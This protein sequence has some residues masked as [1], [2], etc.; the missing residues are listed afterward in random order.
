[1][2]KKVI[3][4]YELRTEIAD[5]VISLL[6]MVLNYGKQ[7]DIVL[8]KKFQNVKIESLKLLGREID[9]NKIDKYAEMIAE[10]YLDSLVSR[11]ENVGTISEQ[12]LIQPITQ[13]HLKVQHV[14]GRRSSSDESSL[15]KL[16]YLKTSPRVITVHVR[17]DISSTAMETADMKG[18]LE[19]WAKDHEYTTFGE[20]IV[21]PCGRCKYVPKPRNVAGIRRK[22]SLYINVDKTCGVFYVFRIDPCKLRD[23]GFTQPELYSFILTFP[24]FGLVIH[25][26]QTL[27]FEICPAGIDLTTFNNQIQQLLKAGLKGIQGVENIEVK[28]I[29]ARDIAKYAYFDKKENATYL[30]CSPKMAMF[31]PKE[32][33]IRRL[34]DIAK[35]PNCLRENAETSDEPYSIRIDG[36]NVQLTDI[37]MEPYF[38]LSIRGSMTFKQMREVLFPKKPD[39]RLVFRRDYLFSNDPVEM[40]DF[41]GI[42][43]SQAIHEYNYWLSLEAGE[44]NLSYEHIRVLCCKMFGYNLCP[45]TPQGFETMAGVSPLDL[46]AYQNYTKHTSIQPVLRTVKHPVRSVVVSAIMGKPYAFGS[47][48]AGFD[49]D[50]DARQAVIDQ[51]S[52]AKTIQHY[53]I[54]Q[55]NSE[56]RRTYEGIDFY[57]VGQVKYVAS[58]L[59]KTLSL[60]EDR[61]FD[62]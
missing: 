47:N 19:K 37:S 9:P 48:Y 51:T 13:A 20:V 23:V 45:I 29:K 43:A 33:L 42:I 11:G 60:P 52:E 14:A 25:P 32:E 1:M 46:L 59:A 34:P 41:L 62:W 28:S 21:S 8:H 12:S 31:F 4:D 58:G 7:S 5:K 38:Y 61:D 6:K 16:N 54:V 26:V 56:Q 40:T 30:Y 10:G 18:R 27:A 50:E 53:G 2:S 39:D 57:G 22:G 17:H 35:R 36:A 15:V 24:G 3:I 44:F 55:A 49:V